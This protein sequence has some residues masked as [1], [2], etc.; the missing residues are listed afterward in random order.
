MTIYA[1]GLISLGLYLRKRASS[2][3]EDYLIGSRSLPWWMLGFSGMDAFLDV[4]GT[5]L[6]VSFL[7]MLGPRGLFVELRGGAVLVLIPM[8]LWTGKWHHRSR[9]LTGAEWM[10]YRFGTGAGGRF[11]QLAKAVSGIVLTIGMLAYL[12]KG[13][14]LFLSVFLPFDPFVCALG[15]VLVATLYTMLSGF[16]GVV[17]TDCFQAGIMIVAVAIISWL[18]MGHIDSLRET[19]SLAALSARVTGN[20]EWISATP[21]W[22]TSMPAGYEAYQDLITVAIIYTLRNLFFGLGAGDDPKYFAA[23]SDA[24][25]AK[26]S[27]LWT[28][29]MSLRWPMMMG[30][31]LIH[32]SEPTRLESKSRVPS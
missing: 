7:F 17:L 2:T 24:D 14:G 6:I 19:D 32:I 18:A 9:C 8:M 26:F 31:S 12:V 22:H 30:L 16:Y 23:K 28:C 11:A 4:A 15:P 5:M 20:A 3:L 29:L 1:V 13:I 21:T 27:L 25:C 10:T